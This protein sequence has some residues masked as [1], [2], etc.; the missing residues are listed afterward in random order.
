[1]LSET[2]EPDVGQLRLFFVEK[3]YWGNGIGSAL[4]DALMDKARRGGYRKIL[5]WTA[6]VL[7]AARRQ[8]EKMG[9]VCVESVPND[10]WS[11]SG[12]TLNEEKWEMA[13]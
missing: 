11:L 1:M 12:Q 2:A 6:D 7:T 4:T 10:K 8:Y 5:L 9:F 13:L 3:K